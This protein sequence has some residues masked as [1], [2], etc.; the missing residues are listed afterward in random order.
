MK[1]SL[2]NKVALVTGGSRGIGAAICK[3]FAAEGAHVGVNFRSHRDLAAKLIEGIAAGGGKAVPLQADLADESE[4]PPMFDKLE[5]AFG[6]VDILVNNAATCPTGPITS[7]SAGDWEATFR[8]NMTGPFVASR[9]HVRRMLD[10]G[11]R[12]KIV[13]IASQAAFRGSETGHLPYDASKGALV[14]FT[15]ALAR[16]LAPQGINVNAIAPGMVL[17]EMVEEKWEKNKERYLARIPM[18]R[19]GDPSEIANVVLFLASDAASYITGATV[20]VSGGM[21]M[22]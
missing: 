21:L 12:G 4:I 18:R 3:A 19:I 7:Y 16:E 17:T 15:I 2:E 22:R 11:R 13:N 5:D 9:E 14:S 1:L 20:D 6:P 8:L 10:S